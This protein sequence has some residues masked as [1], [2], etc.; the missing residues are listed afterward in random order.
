L[1]IRVDDIRERPLELTEEADAAD[2][3]PLAALVESGEA[4][5]T[6]PVSVRV[7]AEREFDHIRITAQASTRMRVTCSRCLVDFDT[8]VRTS[9]KIFYCKG[10][11]GVPTEEEVELSEVDV[12]GASYQGDEIDLT[13]EIG[14]QVVMEIPLKPLCSESCRGLC[15]SC[16]ADLNAGE[17]GCNRGVGDLRF[18]ALKDLKLD[19]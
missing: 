1:K 13:S 19:K 16:G 3:P 5:I 8:D 11:P 2:F 7:R 12:I 6:E 9:F 15:S 4:V 17:C 14:D 18:S 10:D